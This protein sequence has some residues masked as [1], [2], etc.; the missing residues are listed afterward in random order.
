[1]GAKG[2]D[3]PYGQCKDTRYQTKYNNATNG[4]LSN[5]YNTKLDS[6]PHQM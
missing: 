2:N 1:M 4:L 6:V 5:G 3:Y